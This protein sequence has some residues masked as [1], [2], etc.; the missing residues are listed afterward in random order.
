VEMIWRAVGILRTIVQQ[1][2]DVS[3]VIDSLCV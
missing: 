3:D 1:C 2:G